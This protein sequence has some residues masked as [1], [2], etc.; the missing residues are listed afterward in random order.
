MRLTYCVAFI[1]LLAQHATAK[2][3]VTR[4]PLA[5]YS[6]EWNN[7]KY[8]VCNTAANAAYLSDSEK[9]LIYM[10]NLAR[11]DPKLFCKTVLKEYGEEH[12]V[13]PNDE[14]YY[15]TLVKEL[16]TI[17]PLPLLMPDSLCYVSATCHATTS[18][19]TGYVGHDRQTPECK[20]LEHF[21]AECCQ[22]NLDRPLDI[23]V[24]LM[25]DQNVASLGHRR[26]LLSS[27]TRLGV[28]IIAHP[29]KK[30][31]AVLDFYH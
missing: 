17:K 13:N 19:S 30:I 6:P 29:E 27:Y 22:Y 1:M 2:G 20:E 15:K 31:V 14:Q 18:S 3:P 9:V 7:P 11:M 4:S 12:F 25:V 24:S 28:S 10:L 16:M 21:Y 8:K 26:T 23:I 5:A